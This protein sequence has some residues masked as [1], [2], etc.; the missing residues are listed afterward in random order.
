M[1]YN[2]NNNLKQEYLKQSVM[3]ASPSELIVILYDSCIKNLKL[4][5]LCLNDRKD[6]AG[7][8][9][10]LL[11]AQKIIMELINCLDTD[12]ELS[13]QIMEIYNFLLH[14][15][16][17]MNVKK[18]LRL[19]PDVLDILLSLRDTWNKISNPC[20]TCTSEVS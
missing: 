16:R 8:N 11:K 7:A 9:L 10:H 15:I 14:T 6:F 19:L 18:D 13:A 3:T 4:A 20:C 17:E 2:R 5:E 12:F 1:N